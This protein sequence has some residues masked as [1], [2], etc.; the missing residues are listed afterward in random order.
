MHTTMLTKV[1][2]HSVFSGNRKDMRGLAFPEATLSDSK[3]EKGD[4]LPIADVTLKGVNFRSGVPLSPGK[5]H[6]LA[7]KGPN[8]S[9]LASALR[10]VSCKLRADGEFD[11]S[12]EFF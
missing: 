4:L 11:V 5:V 6:F 8:A 3:E 7:A 2:N 9:S 1:R 10:I 12:A